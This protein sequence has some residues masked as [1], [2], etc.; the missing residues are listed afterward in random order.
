MSSVGVRTEYQGR[1]AELITVREIATVRK[2]LQ[3]SD[4]PKPR[5]L[6]AKVQS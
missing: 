4:A 3:R 2:P 5:S 6:R 1:Q